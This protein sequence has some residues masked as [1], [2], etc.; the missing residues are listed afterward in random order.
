MLRDSNGSLYVLTGS[1][2]SD[3]SISKGGLSWCASV[4]FV[5]SS[6]KADSSMGWLGKITENALMILFL[7]DVSKRN[8]EVES[9]LQERHELS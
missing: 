2:S 3:N 5:S 7:A 6:M 4:L 1:S 9:M 8:L